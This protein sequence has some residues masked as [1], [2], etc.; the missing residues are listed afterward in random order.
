MEKKSTNRDLMPI[1]IRYISSS[2]LKA[3]KKETPRYRFNCRA[4]QAYLIKYINLY[5]QSGTH[6]ISGG[7]KGFFVITSISCIKTQKE[8]QFKVSHNH[9]WENSFSF[10]F[11]FSIIILKK[12]FSSKDLFDNVVIFWFCFYK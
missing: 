5:S 6:K 2:Q 10:F 3:S 12:K 1:N 9:T 8:T 7:C 4:H 11:F